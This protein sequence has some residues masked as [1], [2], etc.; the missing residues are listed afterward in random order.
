MNFNDALLTVDL[1]IKSG[2]VPLIIGESGIGKTALVRELSKR[3]KYFL[4]NIDGNLLK[5]GEIGG[6]PTVDEY[7]KNIDGLVKKEKKTVYAIHTKLLQIED[8][9]K[10]HPKRKVLLFIDELNRCEH[11]VQQELMNIILN[12]EINGYFLPKEVDVIAAMNPS[13]KYDNFSQSDYQVVEM[14]PAQEDRFVWVELE[15]DVKTWM[16]WGVSEEGKI[17]ED[18]LQF[19]ASF[20]EYLHTPYSQEAIKATPR[21]WERISKSYSVYTNYKEEY[22]SKIFYNVVK[23]NV[24]GAIAQDFINYLQENRHPLI[25]PEEIFAQEELSEE[26]IGRV[27]GESHSRLYLSSKNALT[28]LKDLQYRDR[29]VK[30]FSKFLQLYPAD[31]KMGIMQEIKFNFK[32]TLYK[33]FM[34]DEIFVEGYFALYNELED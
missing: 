12:R 28:Y 7:E 5:E 14:D 33:E 26:L 22:P 3:E 27:K 15:A 8:A 23:G 10:E 31:L 4:V 20:P 21:S 19:I 29:E 16:Q 11:A 18:V 25:S 13:N 34:G 1:V 17:H 9:I 30:I 6:L 24:G 2:A 32:D